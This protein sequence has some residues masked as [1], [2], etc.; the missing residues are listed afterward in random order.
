MFT[1]QF[2]GPVEVGSLLDLRGPEAKHAINVRRM[3]VGEE[4]QLTDKVGLRVRGH[5]DSILGNALN[6]RVASVQLDPAPI[7][8]LTLVQALAKGDRDE[9]AIQAATE[10]GLIG[11]IPWQADRSVSRWIGIKEDKGVERWQSI[12][13]EAAKQSLNTWHPA[14]AAPVQGIQVAELTKSFDL[15]LVLDPTA[16]AGLGSQS[17]NSGMKIALVVGP[18][19][20]IS[21]AELEA[22]EKS[23]A[24]RVKLGAP[25]LRTS[26]AG[27]AAISAILALTGQWGAK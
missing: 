10:L 16:T 6:V 19:G 27:V 1:R 23:G 7:I 15:T 25:V 20:G 9:L 2:E 21:D 4:I 14:V 8:Q 26:T 13:T 24:I 22:L 11:V 5:V 17:F 18:E 12:V 3:R